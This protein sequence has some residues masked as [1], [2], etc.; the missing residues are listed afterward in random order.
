MNCNYQTQLSNWQ[1]I[2]NLAFFLP[3]RRDE[4][5]VLH[6]SSQGFTGFIVEGQQWEG[7]LLKDYVPWEPKISVF[8]Q[9]SLRK[10]LLLG[11]C[12][13]IESKI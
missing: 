10:L 5:A 12:I 13:D 9:V 8:I 4:D 3:Q 11:I 6:F 2:V 7:F 1:E